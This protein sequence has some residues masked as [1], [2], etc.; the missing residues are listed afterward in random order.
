[1]FINHLFE[2]NEPNVLVVYPGRF[3][4]FHKGHFAV[5]NWLSGRYGRDNVFIAT[6]NKTEPLKSPFSYG[7]KEYFMKLV[8][9]PADRIVESS[10]PYKV[11]ELT[12]RYNPQTTLLIFAVSSKDMQEDPRF[13][14]GTKKDG[15]PTYFQH[16]PRNLR[17]TKTMNEHAYLLVTPTFNFTVLG[18]P[19]DSA[20]EIR[21]LYTNSDQATRQ[22]IIAD[23]FGKYTIEAE[24]IMNHALSSAN[25]GVGAESNP[26]DTDSPIS[27][28]P[29]AEAGVGL[30]RGG[31]D[32]RYVMATTGDQNDVNSKTLGKM[33]KAYDLVGKKAPKTQQTPVKGNIAE[34]AVVQKHRVC[35]TV[36]DRNHQAVT[37]RNEPVQKFIR[38]TAG[39]SEEAVK[40]AV[41]AYKKAG[42]SV[43]DAQHVGMVE[44]GVVNE[45]STEKLAAYKT[46][47]G[48]A[49]TAADKAGDYDLGHKRFKGI[50]KATNKQFAND[51]KK[52]KPEGVAE[53]AKGILHRVRYQCDDPSGKGIAS[54]HITLHAP[55]K[56]AAA[57][58]AVSDL[59]KK[60]KKNVKVNAVTPIKQG[61]AEEQV[62]EVSKESLKSYIKANAE[63]QV[64]RASSDSYMSGRKGDQY[65][66]AD[67]THKDTMRQKGMDRALNKLTQEDEQL[68]ELS[69]GTLKSY[70]KQRIEK[71]RGLDKTDPVSAK[72]IVRKDLP[73]AFT[74]L[75]DP[76][77]GKQQAM[78]VEEGQFNSKQEVIDH[79]VKQGKSAAA[80]ASA[81]ERGWR[82][83]VKKTPK[84]TGP[85][86]S[87]HDDLDDKRYGVEEGWQ[88]FNKVEPYEVCL[89][90]KPIKQFDYYEDARR[91]HDNWKKKLYREGNT[92][93]A[94]KITL[95]PIMKEDSWHGTG[96]NWGGEDPF[97]SQNGDAWSGGDGG[98]GG[99]LNGIMGGMNEAK[100]ARAK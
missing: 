92:E 49:A 4:P 98:A 73:R 26:A 75:K 88:D 34:S 82:G 71:T 16:L 89:A 100:K 54:G 80:G 15:Q 90:G 67:V 50:V 31:N 41:A 44:E 23:L 17:D 94:D 7:D 69:R 21:A 61:V 45:L 53:A 66:T 3:Q 56:I 32:P 27:G 62:N 95:N 29:I 43:K 9:V 91:F 86:R 6:S 99:G 57:R 84:P 35:V 68:D 52:H 18:Q 48:K 19:M 12:A 37:M 59:T 20:T 97:H 70:I 96:D 47:A 58:Y 76:S 5:F 13:K 83:P 1:M 51:L 22:K 78:P 33:M 36:V 63:D 8:G 10:Q 77:Y 38:V 85:V 46:A 55:D 64:Q 81:W 11:P 42:Y 79:F 28:R 93:K 2:S 87:Y 24:Q 30:V 60:G 65:N 39:S 40:K 72:R 25:E 74:K 14:P